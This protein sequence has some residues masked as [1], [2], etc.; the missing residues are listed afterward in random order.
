ML[1]GGAAHYG[2]LGAAPAVALVAAGATIA[3]AFTARTHKLALRR[4]QHERAR[5]ERELEGTMSVCT[6]ERRLFETVLAQLPAAVIVAEAPSGKL[7]FANNK[8]HE[9]WRHP[10]LPSRNVAEY[11]EWK[12][13]HADGRPYAGS[14]WP[15][16]RALATGAIIA[17]EDTD[18]LRGDGTRGVVRL[19]AAPVRDDAGR[20]VAG[21]VVCEDVTELN[22]AAKARAELVARE[23]AAVQASRLKSEFLAT[24]SHEIRTP[25]N[26]VIGMTGLLRTTTLDDVQ[27]EY[28]ETIRES[29]DN[30]LSVVNDILDFSKIEAGQL[31]LEDIPFDLRAQ[32]RDVERLFRFTAEAKGLSLDVTVGEGVPLAVSGDPGRVRQVLNNLLGNAVK[33]T[34]AG[35]VS[36]RAEAWAD[37]AEQTYVEITVRDTGTG[38]TP[39][40]LARL[41][42]PFTQADATTTRRFGGTGLGLSICKRL[43]ERMGGT[44]RVESVEGKGSTFTFSVR[45]RIAQGA[46]TTPAEMAVVPSA[47]LG[48]LR[49]LVVEDNLVNQRI[50]IGMLRLMGVACDLAPNGHDAIEAVK[51]KRYDVILMDCHMPVLDGYAAT[52]AIRVLDAPWC[53]TVPIIAMT[54]NAFAEDERRCLEAGMSAYLSKPVKASALRAA[55]ERTSPVASPRAA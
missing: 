31:E 47:A 12:G 34:A 6:R 16:A 3:L 13:F 25:I 48:A 28:V 5:V 40:G 7:V 2:I 33:F 32:L 10:M 44:I 4:V 20:I 46:V 11:A 54:A 14:D 38:I 30:L 35:R 27:R 37:G 55:M 18:I 19:S 43:V 22:A 41:F 23:Q 21:V 15:L 8:M 36:L 17:K 49:V 29:G 50:A 51:S 39:D 45:L 24:M 26:G 52:R 1:A 42:Q 9:V 53:A